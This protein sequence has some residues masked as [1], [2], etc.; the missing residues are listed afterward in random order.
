[1]FVWSNS[2]ELARAT[3]NKYVSF[4]V[5]LKTTKLCLIV[6]CDI[7]VFH[8]RQ[9][10]SIVFNWIFILF[11][12]SLCAFYPGLVPWNLFVNRSSSN[13][14]WKYR[15][16]VNGR[17]LELDSLT[18]RLCHDVQTK[19]HLQNQDES[20]MGRGEMK[21]FDTENNWNSFGFC[22]L[23]ENVLRIFTSL[24][25]SYTKLNYSTKADDRFLLLLLLLLLVVCLIRFC[26]YLQKH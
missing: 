16:R 17:E 10:C 5:H 8:H 9:T 15:H 26:L 24:S 2:A 13:D 23:L 7:V 25:P 19:N 4:V 14:K 21:V 22:F 12:L 3:Q 18:M 20:W 1:M 6:V 11:S